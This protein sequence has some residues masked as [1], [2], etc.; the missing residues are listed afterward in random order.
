MV[1]TIFFIF[2]FKIMFY[3]L[4]LILKKIKNIILIY[5]KKNFKKQFYNYLSVT[6]K[7][8]NPRKNN[9]FTYY[10]VRVSKANRLSVPYHSTYLTVIS[11]QRQTGNQLSLCPNNLLSLPLLDLIFTLMTHL[12]PLYHTL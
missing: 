8:V 11:P 1:E 6:S 10:Y 5:L 12:I 4:N 2:L 7:L 9:I 3:K